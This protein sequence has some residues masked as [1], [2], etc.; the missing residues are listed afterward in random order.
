MFPIVGQHPPI[1]V[2]RQQQ[3][4]AGQQD[5]LSR[6]PTGR[7]RIRVHRYPIGMCHNNFSETRILE[8]VGIKEA[9]NAA[10]GAGADQ[11]HDHAADADD[12]EPRTSPI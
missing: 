4:Q 11:V 5:N 7:V 8:R 12:G 9:A 2:P 3:G 6:R 1:A 10:P